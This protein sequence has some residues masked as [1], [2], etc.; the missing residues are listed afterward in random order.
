MQ[1]G[2]SG[3]T[4]AA[5][6]GQDSLLGGDVDAWRTARTYGGTEGSTAAHGQHTDKGPTAEFHIEQIHKWTVA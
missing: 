1:D 3:L 4:Q 2:H 5:T 6:C